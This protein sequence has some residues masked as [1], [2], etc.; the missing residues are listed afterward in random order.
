[1]S[2]AQV[3]AN[4]CVRAL[5]RKAPDHLEDGEPPNK[6]HPVRCLSHPSGVESDA[7]SEQ[8]QKA[9]RF[10]THALVRTPL[11]ML[12]ASERACVHARRI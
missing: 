8:A 12:L 5:R 10:I 2:H 6:C 7:C 4:A 11:H 3:H 1:M 9:R